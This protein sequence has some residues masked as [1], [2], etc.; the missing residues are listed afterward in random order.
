M[1]IISEAMSACHLQK[2]YFFVLLKASEKK[3]RM[4]NSQTHFQL[5]NCMNMALILSQ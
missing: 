4:V 3:K 5:R 1:K 2:E